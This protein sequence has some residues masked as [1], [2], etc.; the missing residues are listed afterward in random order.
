MTEI[1]VFFLRKNLLFNFK[2]V[3]TTGEIQTTGNTPLLRVF[4]Q[5]RYLP[6][7]PKTSFS[8]QITMAIISDDFVYK[9]FITEI[10]SCDLKKNF[11]FKQLLNKY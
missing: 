3:Y 10:K 8:W 4:R 5:I 7:Q 11:N 6:V 9:Q 1:F 2:M